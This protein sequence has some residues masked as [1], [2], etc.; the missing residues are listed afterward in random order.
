LPENLTEKFS[1]H[2]VEFREFN[3]LS[4]SSCYSRHEPKGS[5]QRFSASAFWKVCSLSSEQTHHNKRAEVR[6][7][8]L[9]QRAELFD[10]PNNFIGSSLRMNPSG[11]NPIAS[12]PAG[13]ASKSRAL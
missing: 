9:L 10:L 5:N 8:G 11:S 7:P 12:A 2:D 4:E 3:S 1:E 6:P 13:I